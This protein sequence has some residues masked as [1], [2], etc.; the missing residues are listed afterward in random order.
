MAGSKVIK[1]WK[2]CDKKITFCYNEARDN[3]KFIQAMEN[4]CHS[5]YLDDPVSMKESILGLLQTVRLIY[6]VSQ[7]YNT[8]ERTSTLMVKITNQMIET[9]K[10]Y[11]T[12]RGKETIWTQNR[13]EIRTKLTNCL[14]LNQVYRETYYIV[15]SQPFLPDQ[16]P[17]AFSENFVFGKFDTFCD[18]LS[19]VISMFNLVE[20]YN[21]LFERRLE[22]LLLGEALEEAIAVFSD[23]KKEVLS[24][25]YDYLDHR[26]M[27]FNDDFQTFMD[28]TNELKEHIADTIEKNFD[29]VWDTVQGIRFLVRFEKV[30]EKIPLCKMDE[31]YM[32]ILRYCEKE[33]ERI[34]KLFKKQRDEPPLP[35]NFPPIAG[36]IK[37]SRSLELHLSELVTSISSHAVLQ[38]LPLTKDLENRYKSVK[39]ILAEYEQEMTTLW[40]S[41]DVAVADPCLLQP[42]LALQGDKLIVNLHPTI[43]LLIREAKCMAKMG[44][45]IPIVAAT[46]LCKQNHFYV[47]QDSLNVS[48]LL[49]CKCKN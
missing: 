32:R 26:S 3:A 14:K 31:K 49:T 4:C 37:W 46:L 17:F 45:E 1:S 7:F 30:S 39:V 25:K 18:R 35:R 29:T 9:C 40:L 41:Q 22:G 47:I 24:K 5:L 12:N 13:D 34:L 16:A 38:T 48:V 42:V 21:C 36:R 11:I 8:S 23:A 43:T 19:K 10:S 27:E 2:D 44:I 33:I 28:K 20:D 6:S 15:R